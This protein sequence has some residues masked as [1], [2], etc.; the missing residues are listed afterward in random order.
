[1]VHPLKLRVVLE[2]VGDRIDP[3]GYQSAVE[4][5]GPSVTGGQF[6]ASSMREPAAARSYSITQSGIAIIPIHG[7]LMKKS[8]WMS[9]FSGMCTYEDIGE[10][11]EAA[12]ADSAVKHIMLDIDSP[13]GET[14]G[15]FELSDMI[16]GARGKGKLIYASAN[17]LAAS[18]AYNIASAA[19][20]IYVT[21]TGAVGSIGVYSLHAD[22]EGLD[23]KVGIRYTYISAGKYKVDGNPHEA[24]SKTAKDHIQAEV[25]R[26]NSLFLSTVSRN[27]NADE[28]DIAGTNALCFFADNAVPL[29]ADKVGTLDDAM[30]ALE[31]K[32][33][34]SSGGSYPRMGAVVLAAGEAVMIGDVLVSASSPAIPSP[35]D[36]S[37]DPD[38][39][40]DDDGEQL[41]D[42]LPEANAPVRQVP[43][44]QPTPAPP[45]AIQQNEVNTMPDPTL[46][47]NA[48]VP[49]AAP[50]TSAAPVSA[51]PVAQPVAVP[52]T[53]PTPAAPKGRSVAAQVIALC[54]IAGHAEMASDFVDRIEANTMSLDDVITYFNA[55][56]VK[57]STAP[58]TT[59]NSVILG[60]ATGAA[61]DRIQ[62]N[63]VILQANSAGKRLSSKEYERMLL[64]GGLYETHVDEKEAATMTRAGKKKY[65]SEL[66]P[67]LSQMGLGT[68]GTSN[69]PTNSGIGWIN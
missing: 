9:S 40:E 68:T 69:T 43:V 25:N 10:Q 64:A 15:C 44:L 6:Q 20:R 4:A 59:S 32:M 42:P 58:G 17:D 21:R 23:S 46:T 14:H 65:M 26:Q 33:Q 29:L 22:Q 30:E 34:D 18:A 63:T 39:D 35:S 50:V 5:L 1:M 36:P 24:I 3:F 7:L 41:C 66:I 61:L 57:A 60:P 52:A 62:A 47:P 19:D 8:T 27:R 2:T 12:M 31:Q 48:A 51:A 55:E 53:A 54:T 37:L 67:R 13:G 28:K 56:R 45:A 38:E 11:F 49:G 16:Y